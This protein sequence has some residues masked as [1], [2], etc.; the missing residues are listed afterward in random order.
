[1]GIDAVGEAARGEG[2]RMPR[3]FG[4]VG[5]PLCGRPAE[6]GSARHK[7]PPAGHTAPEGASAYAPPGHSPHGALTSE[8]AYPLQSS[9]CKGC[10]AM[11]SPALYRGSSHLQVVI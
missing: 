9:S 1:M 2:K 4:D 6:Q 3:T 8:A 5:V 11:N 7:K 10:C